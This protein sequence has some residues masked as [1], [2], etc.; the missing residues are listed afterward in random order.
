[1]V[2]GFSEDAPFTHN[3]DIV[4]RGTSDPDDPDN[5]EMPMPD[6]TPDVGWKAMGKLPV[7]PCI[8]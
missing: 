3:L 4:L 2:A 8:W 5:V 6:G 7:F 1:M